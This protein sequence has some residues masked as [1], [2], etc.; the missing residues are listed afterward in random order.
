MVRWVFRLFVAGVI[1]ALALAAWGYHSATRMPVFRAARISL[2]G[3]PR[4]AAPVTVALISDVHI[5]N[6]VTDAERFVRVADAVTGRRPDLIVLAGDFI[7]GH[8]RADAAAAPALVPGLRRL[9]AP[10]GVIAVP[11]NHDHWTNVAAV[12]RALARG[13]VAVL[14]NRAVRRGPLAIGGLDDLP[15]RHADV[16]GT[17]AAMRAVAGARL[18]VSHS[19]DAAALLPRDVP[20]VLAGHTHCGQVVVPLFGAPVDVAHPRY[21]CGLVREGGRTTIVTAGTGTSVLPARFGAAPDV[22]LVRVGP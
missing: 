3:W 17:V 16:A 7:A 2:P 19:P 22:W 6:A 21:R 1:A 20:L 18:L 9:R 10:L 11:G 12:R 4:G 13:G 8:E 14:A 15:T 5:G